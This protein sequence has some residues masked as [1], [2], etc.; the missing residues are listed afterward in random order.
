MTDETARTAHELAE[1]IA[2][3]AGFELVET[4]YERKRKIDNITFYIY[5]KE[6]VTIDDCERVSKKIEAELDARDISNGAA[7]CLNV[8]SL[9]LDRPI[10]TDAD[11][12][13]NEGLEVDAKLKAPDDAGRMKIRGI[14]VGHDADYAII[15]E[16]GTEKRYARANLASVKPHIDFK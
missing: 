4:K 15:A 12:A 6:G 2:K 5:R 13:R 10:A 11:F 16:G 3:E 14:L 7:Y 9:G 8:S 1:P